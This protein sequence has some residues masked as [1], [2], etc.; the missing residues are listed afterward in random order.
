MAKNVA[1]KSST[2]RP[3][4]TR[5]P[6]HHRGT[7]A[8]TESRKKAA[9][10]AGSRRNATSRRTAKKTPGQKAAPKAGSRR[11]AA[12]RR[13]AK[14]TLGQKAASNSTTKKTLGKKAASRSTTNKT[15]GKKAASNSTAPYA[16][17]SRTLADSTQREVLRKAARKAVRKAVTR[18]TTAPRRTTPEPVRK[19]THRVRLE[20]VHV[21]RAPAPAPPPPQDYQPPEYNTPGFSGTERPSWEPGERAPVAPKR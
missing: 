5:S 20:P 8:K 2:K 19:T 12:S 3:R 17:E 13:T 4:A 16:G 9:P 6:T 15:L 14:K 10:T 11:N 21:K 1:K 7:L 18:R